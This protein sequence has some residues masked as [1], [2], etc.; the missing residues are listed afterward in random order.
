MLKIS[1]ISTPREFNDV[2]LID[3]FFY[4]LTTFHVKDF[5]KQYFVSSVETDH[6]VTEAIS[7][8]GM[9]SATP[10]LVFLNVLLDTA[11]NNTQLEQFTILNWFDTTLLPSRQQKKIVIESKHVFY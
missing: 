11:F 9:V 10:L 5:A 6:I 8:R 3:K 2:I 7:Q 1:I 4:V